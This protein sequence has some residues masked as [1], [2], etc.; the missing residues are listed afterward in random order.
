VHHHKLFNDKAELYESSRP[1][2]PQEI[3]SYLAS[4]C[5]SQDLAWDSACGNGQ[6]A[7]GLIKE[8]NRVYA[9]DVSKEQIF[10]A[11]PHH[12]ISYEVSPSEKVNLENR[13]CDLICVAQAL[14]WFDYSQFWPEATRVLKPN[15]VFCAFG[16]NWA[17]VSTEIDNVINTSIVKI[18]EP[19]WAPQNK[20]LWNHYRDLQI[21]FEKIESP[22]FTMS[23]SWNLNEYFNFLHTFSATRRCM[24][25]IGNEFFQKAYEA[26][27]HIWGL[28]EERK[29]IDLDFV[30]YVGRKKT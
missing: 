30:F 27:S 29:K 28:V 23:V 18:I 3:Y 24:D 15:G 2:Y 26:V 20:L 1:I 16:Y 6:A 9:T 8:F 14:H 11:K 5:S 19:F 12:N 25:L 10:N 13:S 17:S 7:V 21:P 4:L 22:N